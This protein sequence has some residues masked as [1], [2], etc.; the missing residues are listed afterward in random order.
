MVKEEIVEGLRLAMMKGET[1]QK[2]MMSFFN[3]GY[4][5]QEIEEAARYLQAPTMS[6]YPYPNSQG[7][8]YAMP[9]QTQQSQQMNQAQFQNQQSQTSQQLPSQ[10]PQPLQPQNFPQQTQ[11]PQQPP[12]QTQSQ[13]PAGIVQHVSSYGEPPK[14]KKSSF[15]N[16]LLIF[17][18]LA[19][20]GVLIGIFLFKEEITDFLSR[21]LN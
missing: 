9:Q 15:V 14:R 4:S 5:K 19:L 10:V 11:Q 20:V 17:L 6:Q 18:L 16:F 3:A 13:Q 21:F 7:G 2:A 1:L 12:Q 8:S